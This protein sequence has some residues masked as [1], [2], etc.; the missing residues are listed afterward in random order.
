MGDKLNKKAGAPGL[1]SRAPAFLRAENIAG[2]N[3]VVV[4]LDENRQMG[5]S[6]N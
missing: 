5:Y 6:M 2:K 1:L 3:R 4:L